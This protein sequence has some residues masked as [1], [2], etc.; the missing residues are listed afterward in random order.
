M[1]VE[2]RIVVT[3]AEGLGT[4]NGKGH[5]GAI[6]W[7]ENSLGRGYK[8]LTKVK[9]HE[10]GHVGQVHFI[11]LNVLCYISITTLVSLPKP[12]VDNSE[13]Y[14]DFFALLVGKK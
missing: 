12:N 3:L 10:A 9:M 14:Q 8:V 11:Y 6:Q 1:F 2:I 13:E 7:S 4:L 5:E